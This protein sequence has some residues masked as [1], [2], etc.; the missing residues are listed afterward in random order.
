MQKRGFLWSLTGISALVGFMLTVQISSRPQG[1]SA[2][3]SSY[4][5]LR[6]EIQAQMQENR[7]LTDEIA[8]QRAQL[9]QFEAAQG[10]QS[11]L[12][13]ALQQD[14]KNVDR[15][16]GLTPVN[17]PGITITIRF[18]PNLPYY[19]KTAGLFDEIAD[20]EIGLI[21]NQLFAN[22]ATAIAINGQR[23]V[24]TSSIRLVSSL[25]GS[26]S[27]QVNTV[28][29]VPPYVISAVGD[30]DRMMAVLTL[31]NVQAELATMQEDCII[32]PHRD[33]KGVTVPGYVGRLPGTWAKEVSGS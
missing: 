33:Q 2:P 5:D 29:I 22:G 20:Q 24:T 23:L 3:I 16:A 27:L 17:G 13:K 8:K 10:R 4:V 6:T 11:D 15:E 1:S 32:T 7:I 25:G 26:V 9:V 30:V 21:V 19:D 12:L 31:N 18:D 28:P 14:K